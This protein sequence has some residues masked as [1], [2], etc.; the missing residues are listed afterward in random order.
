MREN[1]PDVL[2]WIPSFAR[3]F[4]ALR[5]VDRR[6]QYGYAEVAVLKIPMKPIL[7]I[8]E[9]KLAQTHLGVLTLTS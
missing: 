3:Q 6:V 5:I 1:L 9:S 2:R 8:I 4:S 7:D